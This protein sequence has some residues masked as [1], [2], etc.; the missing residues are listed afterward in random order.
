MGPGIPTV[1]LVVS[2]LARVYIKT[3]KLELAEPLLKKVLEAAAAAFGTE[4]FRYVTA[5]REMA[6]LQQYNGRLAEAERL[7]ASPSMRPRMPR[8][9]SADALIALGELE[10]V[11][12]ERK[13]AD[14]VLK[15]A[16]EAVAEEIKRRHSSGEEYS[17]LYV[18]FER[19][20]VQRAW[21]LFHDGQKEMARQL[22]RAAFLA[23]VQFWANGGPGHFA[24]WDQPM[25]RNDVT[26]NRL[27][28]LGKEME[29]G[30]VM[31]DI[32]ELFVSLGDMGP[33]LAA[34]RI[35]DQVPGQ[36]HHQRG[37]IYR[38]MSK[39]L[40]SRSE[41][42]VR[43]YGNKSDGPVGEVAAGL[44]VQPSAAALAIAEN[45]EQTRSQ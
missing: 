33:A 31:L 13:K 3:G 40:R 6:V 4:N 8:C 5:L 35:L 23:L 42:E 1:A 24:G 18:P 44:R 25:D 15:R 30:P 22:D 39:I 27:T 20:N 38:L 7:C 11:M 12:G 17:S 43:D 14:A 2:A 21:L 41:C 45:G 37:A 36:T 28:Y 26:L 16:A 9:L 19:A 34:V 10:A 32:A 29:Y